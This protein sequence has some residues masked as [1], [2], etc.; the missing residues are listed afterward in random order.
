MIQRLG[1][2]ASRE[3]IATV[4]AEASRNYET[5]HLPLAQKLVDISAEQ[6]PLWSGGVT[7]VDIL[8]ERPLLLWCCAD[9]KR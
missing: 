7:D 8:R 5:K 9:D 6:G 4:L 1:E 3:E 2:D